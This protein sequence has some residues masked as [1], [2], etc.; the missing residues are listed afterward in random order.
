M[1]KMKFHMESGRVNTWLRARNGVIQIR[2]TPAGAEEDVEGVR[3]V[4]AREVGEVGA[5]S[6]DTWRHVNER[7]GEGDTIERAI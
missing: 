4:R 6:R 2:S 7:L 3:G 1:K 5:N